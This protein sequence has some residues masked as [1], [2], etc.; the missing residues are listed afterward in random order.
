MATIAFRSQPLPGEVAGALRARLEDAHREQPFSALDARAATRR[1]AQIA[2][3]LGLGTTVIRGGLDLDG[4]E[5]DHIWLD[6]DGR[7][8]DVSFPVFLPGFV[9]VLRDFVAG[10]AEA[11][12]LAQV[13]D[14][15]QLGDRVLGAFP[16]PLRYRGQPVWSA[17]H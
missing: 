1:V 8:V 7:V 17:S 9:M 15:A 4:T 3:D 10:H 11:A 16:T 6:V 12:E 5:V 14:S 2:G 13:A